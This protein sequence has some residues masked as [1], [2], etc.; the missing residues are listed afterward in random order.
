MKTIVIGFYCFLLKATSLTARQKTQRHTAALPQDA[1][2]F[3]FWFAKLWRPRQ[4]GRKACRSVDSAVFPV[5]QPCYGPPPA[6]TGDVA[7]VDKT[8]HSES[9]QCLYSI[10]K[11]SLFARSCLSSFQSSRW[12]LSPMSKIFQTLSVLRA[13]FCPKKHN[14]LGMTR[15]A[16]TGVAL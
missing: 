8:K 13:S 3:V 10:Q 15:H 12:A 7:A 2:F 14:Q 4:G 16:Q 6:L 5:C 11:S 9:M 1:A